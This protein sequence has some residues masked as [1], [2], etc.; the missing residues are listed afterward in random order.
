MKT[1]CKKD[2]PDRTANCHAE[3]ERY[4]E[5]ARM[6]ALERDLR[7]SNR[8]ACSAFCE[9]RKRKCSFTTQI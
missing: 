2:C 4:K 6:M 7:A 8:E 5:Y 3:C 1:P 9:G